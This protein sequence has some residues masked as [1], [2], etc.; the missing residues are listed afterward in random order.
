MIARTDTPLGLHQRQDHRF[1]YFA[2]VRD[3]TVATDAESLSVSNSWSGGDGELDEVP[4]V[5]DPA[6]MV[7]I[8][9]DHRVVTGEGQ[10]RVAL[11]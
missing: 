8:G 9:R 11:Q 1:P 7:Q 2:D 4:A 10:R 3:I 5:G 6:H